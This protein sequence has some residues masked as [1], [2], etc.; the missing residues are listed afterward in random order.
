ML[1]L[2]VSNATITGQRGYMLLDFLQSHNESFRKEKGCL[3]LPQK[4]LVYEYCIYIY[5]WNTLY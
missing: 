2:F 1:G 3:K 4:S 5:F